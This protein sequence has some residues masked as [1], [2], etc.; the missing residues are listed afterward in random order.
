MGRG[1]WC[2][3]AILP[4]SMRP[5]CKEIHQLL[6]FSVLFPLSR[7]DPRAGGMQ[8]APCMGQNRPVESHCVLLFVP[9]MQSSA[10]TLP[11]R[12]AAGHT[13][14]FYMFLSVCNKANL[15]FNA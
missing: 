7:H 15:D 10:L 14:S 2:A 12:S 3:S 11:F 6:G 5:Q 9:G 4:T 8:I 1:G 13:L